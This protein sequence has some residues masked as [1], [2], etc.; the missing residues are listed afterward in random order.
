MCT[1]PVPV[2]WG[3]FCGIRNGIADTLIDQGI[4]VIAAKCL[5]CLVIIPGLIHHETVLSERS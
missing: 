2:K 4:K 1:E 5:Y 3:M